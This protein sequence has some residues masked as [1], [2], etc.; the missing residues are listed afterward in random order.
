M[1]HDIVSAEYRGGYSIKLTFDDG[2]TGTVDLSRY[3][4]KGGV[5]ER[6]RD[7]E[8]FKRFRVDL[9]PGVLTWDGEIDIAP[10]TLYAEATN[11]PLPEW[12]VRDEPPAREPPDE[13]MQAKG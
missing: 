4:A 12:M 13:R 9:Q 7:L 5:F 11:T 1:I 8:F 2:K 3:L 6:F 10:E